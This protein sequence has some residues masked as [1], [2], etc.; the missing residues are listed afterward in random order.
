MGL[1]KGT[2]VQMQKA[3]AEYKRQISPNVTAIAKLNGVSKTTL[4]NRL[5]GVVSVKQA[6]ADYLA[7]LSNE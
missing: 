3:I 1:K 6:H 7:L 4:Q 5:K 2:E